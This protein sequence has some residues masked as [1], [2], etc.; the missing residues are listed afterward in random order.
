MVDLPE[1]VGEVM[2]QA[3]AAHH[4]LDIAGIPA[5][6]QK[7]QPDVSDLD[8]RTF[9]HLMLSM[10]M[11]ER[12]GRLAAWHCRE[13]WSGGLVGDYC[14]ECGNLWPCDTYKLATGTYEL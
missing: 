4:L 11:S 6:H 1:G 12:L 9:R 10:D 7:R 8:A 14:N 2:E 3:L 5:Q 13:S